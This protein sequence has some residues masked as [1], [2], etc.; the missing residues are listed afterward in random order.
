ME[1]GRQ[2]YEV[3]PISRQD[4]S[5]TSNS[6]RSFPHEDGVRALASQGTSGLVTA[7]HGGTGW[8]RSWGSCASILQILGIIS[9]THLQRLFDSSTS[10]ET[11]DSL[12][13]LDPMIRSSRPSSKTR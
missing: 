7:Y 13:C 10:R 5:S 3:E 1:Q 2:V 6:G 9:H 12:P 8:S 4:K 11:A